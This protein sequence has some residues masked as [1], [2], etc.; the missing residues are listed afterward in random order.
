MNKPRS[1][2]SLLEILI[3]LTII[4]VLLGVGFNYYQDSVEEA[5]VNTVKLNLRAV[6]EAMAR[7]F[8]DKMVYPTSLEDLQGT[9]LQQ[10]VEALILY[11]LQ[12][13][14]SGA[15][16]E[17]RVSNVAETNVYHAP[18]SELVWTDNLATGKQFKN[19]RV[20]YLN[21]YLE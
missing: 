3:V 20:K 6:K 15:K 11:P 5:R 16:I 1:G 17:I 7:Y 13:V 4:A 9:Y 14:D 18:E 8:K 19:I 21:N 2:F 10:K 12:K